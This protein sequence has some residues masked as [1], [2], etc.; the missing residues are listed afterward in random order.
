MSESLA[1]KHVEFYKNQFLKSPLMEIQTIGKTL[2]HWQTEIQNSFTKF[3]DF[4]QL[5]NAKAEARN[6]VIQ[7]A[8]NQGY[9]FQN[10]TRFR[11]RILLIDRNKNK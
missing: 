9:G 6:N 10:F 2:K 5:S 7:K 8:K 4:S 1:Y 3:P 11:K